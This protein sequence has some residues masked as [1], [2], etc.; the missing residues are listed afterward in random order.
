MHSRGRGVTTVKKMVYITLAN[1]NY[2][3]L[4]H[5][6]DAMIRKDTQVGT[7]H[8]DIHTHI[9]DHYTLLLTMIKA[10][11]LIDN[12]LILSHKLNWILRS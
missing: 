1:F 3:F 7:R 5:M 8:A 11:L 9:K 10:F 12:L 4:T 2:P 6:E